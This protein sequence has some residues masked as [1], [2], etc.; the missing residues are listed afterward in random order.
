MCLA[1]ATRFESPCE[2][3][4]STAP[5]WNQMTTSVSSRASRSSRSD[6]AAERHMKV[7]VGFSP[8]TGADAESRR[9]ATPEIAHH[10]TPNRSR[11]ATR[12]PPSLRR[13]RGLKPEQTEARIRAQLPDE[14]RRKHST[15]VITNEGTIQELRVKIA[16]L[17]QA[18]LARN[19]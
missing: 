15:L 17:W 7:A 9:V 5:E 11:V 19:R 1:E 8:R 14:E 16:D 10:S 3:T 4:S 2:V 18:A 6:G 12:R 13:D